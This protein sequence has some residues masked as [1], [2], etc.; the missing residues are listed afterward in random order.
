[1][2]S[3]FAVSAADVTDETPVIVI[4]AGHGG[5]DG[6]ATSGIRYEKEYDLLL[7]KYLRDE[8]VADGRFVVIMTRDTDV[9][10]NFLDRTMTGLRAD[11]DFLISLH[12]NSNTVYY[13]NG[14][15]AYISVVDEYNTRPLADSILNGIQS[16]V[17]IKYNKVDSKEDTGD[18]LG[19]YYW[20]KDK[21]WDMPGA[22]QLGKKS[23]FYSILTWSSK[24]GIPSMIL[25]AG[26]L[27]NWS[28]RA[29]IDSDANLK[30]IAASIA[31][32]FAEHY[33]GHTHTFTS[34]KVVVH[35]SNCSLTGSEAYR[36]TYCGLKKGTTA[37]A[38]KDDHYWRQESSAAATCTT[39]GYINYVCQISF[40]LDDKGYETPVHRYTEKIPA[41][42][43]NYVVYSDTQSSHAV[44]GKLHKVCS[45]C[46]DEILEIRQGTPHNYTVAE[47]VPATCDADGYTKY[48][49]DICS[50]EYS[51]PIKA[52]GH[53]YE[54]AES[55]PATPSED[56]YI[57]Y[58]CSVCGGEKV[59]V[60]P[61]CDHEFESVT[62]DPTCENEGQ[63]IESCKKCGYK[64]TSKIDPLGHSYEVISVIDP[65][66]TVSGMIENQCTVCGKHTS[67]VPAPLGHTFVLSSKKL[68]K[69]INVCSLCG[70]EEI[71]KNVGAIV[72]LWVIG[73][74]AVISLAACGFIYIKK[75][76]LP[77]KKTASPKAENKELSEKE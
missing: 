75:N 71:V 60:I 55:V 14:A 40:N 16:S 1:M 46:G 18:S 17:G 8:L 50:E 22:W 69:T 29:I 49:C 67:D 33:F 9:Y 53:T 68:T 41:K 19:I 47:N 31:D 44:D 52:V 5:Y 11:A 23:D 20:N 26:Y 61:K 7:A 28:D 12:C 34:Q 36:C 24:F 45:T 59:T 73:T 21:K 4:D 25:E 15:E 65:T 54:E 48:R 66:C 35:P 10:M 70:E 63:T 2:S 30:K 39:D 77:Q 6:G 3:A 64:T 38:A 32:S 74:A 72:I 58:I 76:G 13:V 57:K 56:G 37:L 62:T 27:S 42:G 43:H 51:D